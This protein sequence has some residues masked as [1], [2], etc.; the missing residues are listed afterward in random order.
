[1]NSLHV[2]VRNLYQRCDLQLINFP[3][4]CKNMTEYDFQMW[5]YTGFYPNC[6]I[7]NIM[8]SSFKTDTGFDEDKT[9]DYILTKYGKRITFFRRLRDS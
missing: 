9:F 7:S 5:F 8:I 4:E 3:T 2:A 1:M 6:F